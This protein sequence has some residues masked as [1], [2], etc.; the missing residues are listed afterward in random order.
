MSRNFGRMATN[1]L[2]KRYLAVY[3]FFFLF[4]VRVAHNNNGDVL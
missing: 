4:G 3:F 2:E 1:E